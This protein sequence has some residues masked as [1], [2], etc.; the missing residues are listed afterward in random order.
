MLH[1]A[2]ANQQAARPAAVPAEE[3]TV[4]ADRRHLRRYIAFH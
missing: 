3:V 2:A 4:D 1:D